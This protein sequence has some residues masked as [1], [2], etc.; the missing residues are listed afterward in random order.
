MIRVLFFSALS[1]AAGCASKAPAV[2][3]A[4]APPPL[5]AFLA[6][7]EDGRLCEARQAHLTVPAADASAA[8][9]TARLCTP[10]FPE[11][12]IARGYEADCNVRFE[13]GPD[14]AARLPSGACQVYGSATPDWDAFAR[15]A[16]TRLAEMSVLQTVY[17]ADPAREQ[18]ATFQ[19]RFVFALED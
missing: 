13:L 10:V 14:G 6:R 19:R 9:V 11:A 3:Q 4:E 15:D 1:A 8:S 16:F 12:L 2:S 18:S 5:A 7:Y 17:S